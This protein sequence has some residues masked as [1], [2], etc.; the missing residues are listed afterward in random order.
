M[1]TS[2]IRLLTDHTMPKL[3]GLKWTILHPHGD[4]TWFT[5][6]DPVVPFKRIDDGSIV[7]DT[8][9]E[10]PG[11]QILFPIGPRHLLYTQV[12]SKSQ[13]RGHILSLEE[14]EAV[15]HIVAR[16]AFRNI[17]AAG[18]DLEVPYLRPMLVDRD[19]FN[20]EREYWQK[21]P[22]EQ[23]AI[24]RDFLSGADGL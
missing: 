3:S 6:D 9:W 10:S 15:R 5:S 17:F 4:L 12:G 13:P 20:Q 24:D 18:P 1:W 21:W 19:L 2:A 22:D 8:G 23:A 14:T 11:T 16:H 7:F